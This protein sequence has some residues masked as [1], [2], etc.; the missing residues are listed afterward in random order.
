MRLARWKI[1][2]PLAALLL[3]AQPAAA[4]DSY[5]V[6]IWGSDVSPKR[7][8]YTHTWATLVRAV[9]TPGCTEPGLE[10]HTISWLPTKLDIDALNFRVEPGANVELHETIANSLRTKQEIA[11]WGPY[12][13]WHGLAHRFLVQKAFLDSGVVGYQCVDT[14]GEAARL[15]RRPRGLGF[16]DDAEIRHVPSYSC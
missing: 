5:Y 1:A 2:L 15:A 4:G 10:V 12:E 7:L 16:L 9:E 14:V 11:M 3:L 13:V 8:K 6:I